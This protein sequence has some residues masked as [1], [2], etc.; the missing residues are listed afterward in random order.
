MPPASSPPRSS[1]TRAPSVPPAGVPVGLQS[2]YDAMV[3]RLRSREAW[4]DVNLKI[5]RGWVVALRVEETAEDTD[6]IT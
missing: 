5:K 4:C 2:G 6:T 3:E 1:T